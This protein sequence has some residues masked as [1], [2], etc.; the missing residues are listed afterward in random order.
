MD[1]S[2][3]ILRRRLSELNDEEF[4]QMLLDEEVDLGIINNSTEYSEYK[5][6]LERLMTRVRSKKRL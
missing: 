1:M 5:S 6:F 4:I 3:F 2:T